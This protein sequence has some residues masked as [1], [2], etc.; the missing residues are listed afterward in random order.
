VAA[1]SLIFLFIFRIN[2]MLLAVWLHHS[3]FIFVL[4][5]FISLY[6]S[7][8]KTL[9]DHPPAYFEPPD[10]FDFRALGI[11]LGTSFW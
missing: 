7:F 11:T 8:K 5:F 10:S 3:R 2:T 9:V 6:M 1:R 4:F